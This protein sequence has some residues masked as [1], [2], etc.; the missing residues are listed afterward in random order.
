M[1]GTKQKQRRGS[2]HT[3]AVEDQEHNSKTAYHTPSMEKAERKK[4]KEAINVVKV[5]RAST[6]EFLREEIYN[7]KLAKIS[8]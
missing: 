5:Y 2:M 6:G 4:R 7:Y 1:I 8:W 3:T